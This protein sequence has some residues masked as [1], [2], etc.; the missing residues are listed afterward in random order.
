MLARVDPVLDPEAFV[1]YDRLRRNTISNSTATALFTTAATANAATKANGITV[2][3]VGSLCAEG[4]TGELCSMCE[5][6]YFRFNVNCYQCPEDPAAASATMMVGVAAVVVLW[7]AVAQG[8][9][10]LGSDAFDI[11]LLFLQCMSIVLSFQ[12]HHRRR[13][14]RQ[15]QQEVS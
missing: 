14:R 11:L 3:V 2:S 12:V 7:L 9:A 1:P 4:Y 13:V 5:A 6:G 15:Q 8:A 10:L